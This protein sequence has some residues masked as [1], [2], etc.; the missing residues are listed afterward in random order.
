MA[1]EA[2]AALWSVLEEH[3]VGVGLTSFPTSH[4]WLFDDRESASRASGLSLSFWNTIGGYAT[5]S[6]TWIVVED[7]YSEE[8]LAATT[9]H[10]GMHLIQSAVTGGNWG[11]QCLAEGAAR[12][13]DYRTEEQMGYVSF[14]D[15]ITGLR[16]V[17]YDEEFG[18]LG[19]S[20]EELEEL[21]LSREQISEYESRLQAASLPNLIELSARAQFQKA[22]NELGPS[23]YSLCALAFDLLVETGG[24]EDSYF[25]YLTALRRT[26]WKTAFDRVFDEP[27][28]VFL[29]R[30]TRYRESG[31]ED[32]RLAHEVAFDEFIEQHFSRCPFWLPQSLCIR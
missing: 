7:G 9:A 4:V 14:N 21:G 23:V 11:S 10:E 13:Y 3:V 19:I 1:K 31:F 8:R 6:R 25:D 18:D 17:S 15:Q 22:Y 5:G 32:Y 16:N 30:F 26:S 27:L 12:W 24:G 2:I 29:E 28:D 20:A